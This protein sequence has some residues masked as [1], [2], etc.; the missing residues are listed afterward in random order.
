MRPCPPRP[1]SSFPRTSQTPRAGPAGELVSST[2]LGHAEPT[3]I[4]AARPQPSI[5]P[6]LTWGAGPVSAPDF[7]DQR[8]RPREENASPQAQSQDMN[9]RLHDSP[10]QAIPVLA[11]KA[12]QTHGR[13]DPTGPGRT[14]IN[15]TEGERVGSLVLPG[16]PCTRPQKGQIHEEHSRA[17]MLPLCGTPAGAW[18]H[19]SQGRTGDSGVPSPG[20]CWPHLDARDPAA[21][22]AAPPVFSDW[23]RGERR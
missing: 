23:T 5:S 16:L 18:G 17:A 12:E 14:G 2:A 8:K 6:Q 4:A 7:P 20:G 15:C 13:G 11:I 9:P 10:A 1:E 19:L 3:L 22:G 21:S